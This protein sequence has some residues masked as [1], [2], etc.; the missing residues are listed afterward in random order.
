[1]NIKTLSW[2]CFCPCNIVYIVI[3]AVVV[4]LL[5]DL[6]KRNAVMFFDIL[7]FNYFGNSK[8]Q[9]V[10]LNAIPCSSLCSIYPIKMN[11]FA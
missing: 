3:I 7:F 9:K 1:M 5:D 10:R 2:R 4:I 6:S 11:N 8:S